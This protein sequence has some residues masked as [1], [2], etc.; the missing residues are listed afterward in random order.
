MKRV[1]KSALSLLGGAALLSAAQV[2]LPQQQASAQPAID[3]YGGGSALIFPYY[4]VRDGWQ[5]LINITNTTAN[6]LAVKIRIHESH[7]TRDVL[8]FVLMMSPYDAWTA[9]LQGDASNRPQIYTTD[10]SC[11]SPV[12]IN[13]ATGNELAYTQEF[14]DGGSPSPARMGEGYIEVLVMGEITDAGVDTAPYYAEHVEKTPGALFEP[15]DCVAADARWVAAAPWDTVSVP[16]SGTPL[17]ETD[18]DVIASSRP[19]KGNLTLV[20][21][22][23]GLAG[24]QEAVAVSDWG[25]GLNLVTAQQFPFFLEPTIAS[26]AG[27]WSMTGLADVDMAFATSAIVNEWSNLPGTGAKTDWVV[28]FPTKAYHVDQDATNIQAACNQ[29][30]QDGAAVDATLA[31]CT[32]A[33]FEELFNQLGTGRSNITV[34]YDIY[35]REE[36]GIT[37]TTDG[38]VISPAPPP[39]VIINTFPYETNVMTIG[40]GDECELFSILDSQINQIIDTQQLVSNACN[41]WLQVTFP[42]SANLPA[43]GFAFKGRDFGDPDI[44]YG[45]IMDHAYAP[46]ITAGA[47]QP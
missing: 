30:R 27:L 29:W 35:D 39:E 1:C 6:H 21:K 36:G 5:S 8:D 10:N 16:G 19:L 3:R 26:H 31:S 41:G 11:T 38:T 46:P 7:N 43:V 37:I 9:Y 28:T 47:G 20:N 24:G 15:R 13:G 14:A 23:R 18:Y 32:L 45:Q 25:L 40:N 2:M 4:T 17:A 12:N 33:P 44:S 22:G 34:Q 42:T